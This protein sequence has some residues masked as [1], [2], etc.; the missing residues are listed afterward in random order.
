MRIVKDFGVSIP[1]HCQKKHE[2]QAD[3]AAGFALKIIINK[4][5]PTKQDAQKNH[6]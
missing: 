3:I 4:M 1:A 6:D 2:R 5:A